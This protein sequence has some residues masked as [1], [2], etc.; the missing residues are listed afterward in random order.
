LDT[1]THHPTSFPGNQYSQPTSPHSPLP[2]RNPSR[3]APQEPLNISSVS[4][5]SYDKPKSTSHYASAFAAA[6]ALSSASTTQLFR[7]QLTGFDSY[8]GLQEYMHPA[9]LQS[10][11]Y[12]ANPMA[13]KVK[14][15]PDPDIPNTREVLTGSHA[16]QHWTSMSAEIESLESKHTWDVVLRS[17]MPK[18]IKAIPGTWC[19]C[20]KQ[21]PDGSLNNSRPDGASVEIL[22]VTRMMAIPTHLTWAG[23]PCELDCY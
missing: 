10:P 20:I 9:T 16:E 13:L 1:V 3:H 17:S 19:H 4:G 21:H 7:H 14:K 22:S 2:R 8:N 11:F 18:G 15:A 5:Q 23:P 12:L 6:L